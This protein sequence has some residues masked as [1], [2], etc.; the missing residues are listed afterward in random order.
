MDLRET[1]AGVFG[2]LC[3]IS[4]GQ[5][6]DVVKAR[7]QSSNAHGKSPGPLAVALQTV[8]GE[9]LRAL[10]K[11]FTPALAS[12]VTENIVV[13]S[14]NSFLRNQLEASIGA[15]DEDFVISNQ[16]QALLGALTGCVSAV[17][18]CPAEVLKVRQQ[19]KTVRGAT[20]LQIAT[21]VVRE[22]GVRGLFRGVGPLLARDVPFY[23][24][25]FGAMETFWD[26]IAPD[27]SE[28][29]L[30]WSAVGGGFGGS[31]AWAIVF[32]FDVAKTRQQ[33]YGGRDTM[34]ATMR[35]VVRKDG[36]QGLYRGWTPA[37]LRAFPA[38]GALV[39]G[40]HLWRNIYD[41]IMGED[42]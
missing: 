41:T 11:G 16:Q 17:A 29:N 35:G 6:F 8:R 2:A 28:N 21:E 36:I 9:G 39:F 22:S 19:T 1:S 23:F 24:L 15:G 32:P 40:V 31:L 10:F 13:W 12:S 38:N 14:V 26:K 4:C 5:P 30:L 3:C 7:L 33:V 37:V 42:I 20:S 18:I 25:F 34:L 27:G